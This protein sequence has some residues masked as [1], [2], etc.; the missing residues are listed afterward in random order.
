MVLKVPADGESWLADV[1]FGGVGLLEPIALRDGTVAE[2]A[3]L[4]YALRRDGCLW[5]LSM[6]DPSLI[7]SL[8]RHHHVDDGPYE[9]S[10]SHKPRRRR[11]GEPFHVDA[12]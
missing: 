2:Q 3:G 11:G 5:I 1:G 10:E 4:T 9:F 8:A 7:R 12:S 6:R